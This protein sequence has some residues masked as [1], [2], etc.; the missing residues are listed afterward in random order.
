MKRTKDD[1]L[2][3]IRK[4]NRTKKPLSWKGDVLSG[5][6]NRVGYRKAVLKKSSRQFFRYYQLSSFN[7]NYFLSS[8]KGFIALYRD[9][10]KHALSF[11]SLG[12]GAFI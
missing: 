8:T 5:K 2:N 7:F 11:N 9:I 4:L 3:E 1:S 6:Q 12:F 10:Y